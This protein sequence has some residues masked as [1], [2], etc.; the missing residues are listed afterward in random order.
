MLDSASFPGEFDEE[1]KQPIALTNFVNVKKKNENL[2]ESWKTLNAVC[3]EV[4][5]TSFL[6][7]VRILEVRVG[8][9]PISSAPV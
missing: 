5:K 6:M 9:N 4:G 1:Q 8:S 7:N 3:V 2:K